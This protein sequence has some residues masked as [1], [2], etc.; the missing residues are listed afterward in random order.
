MTSVGQ[1][2]S[3]WRRLIAWIVGVVD[4]GDR[5]RRARRPPRPRA[6]LRTRPARASG[7]IARCDW[8]SLIST[9]IGRGGVGSSEFGHVGVHRRGGCSVR[10]SVDQAVRCSGYLTRPW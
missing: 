4:Q 10:S 9:S 8:V 3:R 6:T 2:W 7:S 1:S 5:D